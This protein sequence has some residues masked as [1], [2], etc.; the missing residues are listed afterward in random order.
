VNA[1]EH[2][3]I[4]VR[5]TR[6]RGLALQI[7][8]RPVE[9]TYGAMVMAE[10]SQLHEFPEVRVEIDLRTTHRPTAVQMARLIATELDRNEIWD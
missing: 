2:P 6:G 4:D 9:D 5:V 8:G 7:N 1:P 10:L 3:D